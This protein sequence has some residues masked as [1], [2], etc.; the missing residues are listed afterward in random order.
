QILSVTCDNASNND[1]MMHELEKQVN[2]LSGEAS[3]TQCFLHIVNLVTKTTIQLFDTPKRP[4]TIYGAT[5]S[6][7]MM[8]SKSF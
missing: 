4:Q 2:A 6:T 5:I 1:I 7:L 3:L 8:L